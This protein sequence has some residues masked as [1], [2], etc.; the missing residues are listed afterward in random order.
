MH[1]NRTLIPIASFVIAQLMVPSTYKTPTDGVYH[2]AFVLQRTDSDS[3]EILGTG[4]D[5]CFHKN[6]L[7]DDDDIISMASRNSW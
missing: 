3:P 2:M 4:K 7:K 6:K 5:V 1:C